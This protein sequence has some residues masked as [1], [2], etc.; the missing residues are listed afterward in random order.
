MLVKMNQNKEA[1]PCNGAKLKVK[2][3]ILG[4]VFNPDL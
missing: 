3:A 4:T 2:L 1:A